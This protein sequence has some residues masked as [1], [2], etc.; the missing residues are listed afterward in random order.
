[1]KIE[2]VSEL[3]NGRRFASEKEC[4]EAEA[5]YARQQAA[6]AEA[7][8]KAKEDAE[9]KANERKSDAAKVEA[10]YKAVVEAQKEYDRL[11]REFVN[12]YNS[13]HMTISNGDMIKF[14]SLFEDTL[15]SL[16]RLL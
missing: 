13:Y 4:K 7:E 12:K 5:T 1:M 2:Y 8:K 14:D 6:K 10:A 9:K 3:L 11:L 15:T 16:F